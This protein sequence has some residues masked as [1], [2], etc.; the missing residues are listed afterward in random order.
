MKR[1][2]K[3]KDLSFDSLVIEQLKDPKLAS[4]YLNEHISYEGKMKQNL[5]LEALMKVIDAHGVNHI[6]NKTDVA[7]RTIYSSF[8]EKGNPTLATLI[9]VM[10]ELGVRIKF[11]PKKAS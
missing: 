2:I 1:K 7:R 9:A 4:A 3:T 10:D 6:V 8:K 11:E 5:L